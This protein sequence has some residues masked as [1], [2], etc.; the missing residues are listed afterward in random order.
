LGSELSTREP[1]FEDGVC[2]PLKTFECSSGIK[3]INGH[4]SDV[5]PGTYYYLDRKTSEMSEIAKVRPALTNRALSPVKAVTY[6]SRD[7]ATIPA[8]I[9]MPAGAS[10]KNMPAVVL[11]HGGPSSRDEWGF[12]WLPQFL[13]ARGYVVI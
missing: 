6:K 9:T 3:G 4:G 8:Y 12:D 11:P 5:S 7:G 10:G 13:A 2:S 1:L